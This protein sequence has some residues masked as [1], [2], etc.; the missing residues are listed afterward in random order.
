[1]HNIFSGKKAVDRS[2]KDRVS[3]WRPAGFSVLF[4]QVYRCVYPFIRKSMGKTYRCFLIICV[5]KRKGID[6]LAVSQVVR[7]RLKLLDVVVRSNRQVSRVGSASAGT[8][9]DL[10]D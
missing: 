7:R 2:G 4:N 3:L 6:L 10:F 8:C 9:G 1:M 5:S